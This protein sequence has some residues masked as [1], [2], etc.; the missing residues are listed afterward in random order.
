MGHSYVF[1]KKKNR[2]PYKTKS[3]TKRLIKKYIFI[4]K[5]TKYV[6]NK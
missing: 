2:L 5:N 1:I 4:I 3:L 6:I